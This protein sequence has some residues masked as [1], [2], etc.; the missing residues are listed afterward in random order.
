MI[1]VPPPAADPTMMR[2]G[3]EGNVWA[4]TQKHANARSSATHLIGIS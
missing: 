1:S 3:R 2:T 4:C